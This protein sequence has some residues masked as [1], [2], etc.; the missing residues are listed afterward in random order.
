MSDM[1]GGFLSPTIELW[2]LV[3]TPHLTYYAGGRQFPAPSAKG[4]GMGSGTAKYVRRLPF[5]RCLSSF[6][7]WLRK[8]LPCHWNSQI[9]LCKNLAKDN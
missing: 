7:L 1:G 6:L 4:N 5:Y 9:E 8:T 2:A 3:T